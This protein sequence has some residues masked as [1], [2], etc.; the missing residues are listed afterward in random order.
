VAARPKNPRVSGANTSRPLD[1]FPLV[2]SH[3]IDEV[4][5]AFARAFIRPTLLAARGIEALDTTFNNCRL[6]NIGLAYTTFGA[7]VTVDFPATGFFLQVFPLRG[8]GEI[9]YGQTAVPMSAGSGAVISAEMSH[10]A[11][12]G[13]DYEHLVLRIGARLLTD[14][15]AAM[16]GATINEPLRLEPEQDFKHPSAQILQQYLPFL[17]DTLSGAEPPFPDWWVAQTEQLLMTLFLCGHRHN[18]SHLMEQSGPDAAPRQVRQAEE[19][20]VAN[21]ERAITLEELAEVTGVSGFS[22]FSAFRKHRGYSPLEFLMQVRSGR[23][24]LP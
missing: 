9:V 8:S 7:D 11:R 24:R 1:N 19:F 15:L 6:Q 20:I 3:K 10:V 17:V 22:L 13:A 18:Y 23:R 5:E 21:A 12:L 16:T 14:K 4:C 2:R